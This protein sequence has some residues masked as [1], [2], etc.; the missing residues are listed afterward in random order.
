M[1]KEADFWEREKVKCGLCAHGCRIEDGERGICRVRENRGGTLYSLVYGKA[2]SLTPDPIEKK[3]L[4]HFHPGTTALSFGTV[5]CNFRCLYCQNLSLSQGDPDASYLREIPP[6]D[7]ANMTKRY[8]G[9]AWTYNEPTM[10]YEYSYDVFKLVKGNGGYTVYVTNGYMEKGPLK[11]IGP[12]LDAM[13]ID[14]KAFSEDFYKKVVGA[15]LEPVLKTCRRG[16]ELGIHI[17]LT[18]LV[19]PGYNDGAKEVGEF[20]SWVHDELDENIVVHFSRF[21]P[22]HKMRD[23][24]PTPAEKMREVREIA[25]EKGLNYVYLGNLPANN[26]TICHKCGRTVLKRGYFSSGKDELR[27]GKCPK[28]GEIIPIVL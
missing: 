25:H 16:H 13:N 9:I 12:Y 19:V 14:V 8:D 27:D 7:I 6:E 17:E 10:S 11:K 28:C 23:L 22:H 4:Y 21:H 18:Y 3:P 20:C 2:A 24:S 1:I 26:D 15:R 5:G